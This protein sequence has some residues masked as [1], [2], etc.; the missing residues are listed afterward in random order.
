MDGDADYKL[1]YLIFRG[2]ID[3]LYNEII[4]S[5]IFKL[6]CLDMFNFQNALSIYV[7]FSNFVI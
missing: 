1:M 5:F 3:V 6:N 7:S 4:I 2:H